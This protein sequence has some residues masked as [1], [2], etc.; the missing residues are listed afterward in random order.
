MANA[1]SVNMNLIYKYTDK[2]C[3][4]FQ[5]LLNDTNKLWLG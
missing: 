3:I 1:L 4:F 2:N 5:R